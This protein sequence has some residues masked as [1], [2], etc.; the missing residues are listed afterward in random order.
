[1]SQPTDDSE[2]V[3]TAGETESVTVVDVPERSRF[4]IAVDGTAAGF[5]EYVDSA[6]SG[7][8]AG[9]RTFPHTVIEEAFGGRGLAT[10]LIRTALDAT[11]VAGLAVIPRCPAVAHFLAKH[12]EYADLVPQSRRAEFDL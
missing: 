3:D 9:E 1:M 6:A 10:L 11:R 5:T 2:T 12:P 4:E 8:T 7:D